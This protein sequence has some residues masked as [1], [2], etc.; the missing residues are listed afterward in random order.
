VKADITV[1]CPV[2]RSPRVLQAAGMFDVPVEEKTSLSWSANLPLEDRD[3]NVG[4]VTGPSG[5]GKSQLARHLWPE[6]IVGGHD[7]PDDAALID[8]FP[9]AMGIRDV[10][11]LLSA[12]G[13]SSPPGC[14]LT[15][16]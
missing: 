2:R 13:L 10:T 4:L 15:G 6:A 14:A 7:W 1:S 3:W 11:G 5:A 8:G 12:T 9:E 16:R